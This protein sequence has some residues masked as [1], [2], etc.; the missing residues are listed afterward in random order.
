MSELSANARF[1]HSSSGAAG[2]LRGFV[3]AGE[4]R[5]LSSGNTPSTASVQRTETG[6]P[7]RHPDRSAPKESR[8]PQ[9]RPELPE[10]NTWSRQDHQRQRGEALR[11]ARLLVAERT[12]GP[13][14]QL[15]LEW[16]ESCPALKQH[17][18]FLHF[19]K[20]KCLAHKQ[21]VFICVFL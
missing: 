4:H 11:A 17:T 1:A 21:Q 16:S 2:D 20:N 19:I 10:A 15:A 12:Q 14:S 8:E 3:Q 9:S 6:S 18:F 13:I 7:A 5:R